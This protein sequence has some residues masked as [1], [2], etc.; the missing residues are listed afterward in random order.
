MYHYLVLAATALISGCLITISNS[1]GSCN[2]AVCYRVTFIEE[3]T[4]GNFPTQYPVSAHFSPLVGAVHGPAADFFE[5]NQSASPGIESMAETGSTATLSGEV[6]N[7]I[8]SASAFRLILGGGITNDATRVSTVFGINNA[9]PLVSLVSMVA[10]SPDWFVGV[11]SLNLRNLNGNFVN[12]LTVDLVVYDAGTDQGVS[13]T[14]PNADDNNVITRLTCVDLVNHCGFSNG[15]G[16]D[17][18]Q[19][20]GRFV[21]ERLR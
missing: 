21:F 16:T 15:I 20:I 17:G 19:F 1:D 8:N 4:A 13:F 18:V 7:A 14:S 11:D 6:R 12:S 10:P 5:L 2:A 9:Y 3:W